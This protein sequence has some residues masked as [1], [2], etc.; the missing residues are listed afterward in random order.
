VSSADAI[1]AYQY[2]FWKLFGANVADV[3][4]AS[5]LVLAASN[6]LSN[7]KNY[8]STFASL[9]VYTPTGSAVSNQ[10]FLGLG[11]FSAAS[12]VPEPSSSLLFATGL[13]ILVAVYRKKLRQAKAALG[14]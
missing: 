14:N 7:G 13:V 12:D 11:G 5:A 4:N 1:T 10:E 3:N 6:D 8:S 2:A 9:R